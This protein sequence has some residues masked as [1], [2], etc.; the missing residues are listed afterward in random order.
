ML[1]GRALP[2]GGPKPGRAL[3]RVALCTAGMLAVLMPV[4]PSG[5]T[6]RSGR[7]GAAVSDTSPVDLAANVKLSAGKAAAAA[8]VVEGDARFEVLSPELIRLEYSPNAHFLDLPTFDVLDRQFGHPAFTRSVSK[9]WLVLRTSAVELRYRL[10]S[11]PFDPANTKLQ[12]LDAGSGQGTAVSPSWEWECTFGQACQAGAATLSGGAQLAQNHQ[13]YGSPAGFVAGLT[14]TGAAASWE[15]LG[16]PAGTATLT[17][18]YSNSVGLLGG[19][20]PRTMS[21]V[22]DGT[23]TTQVTMQPTASWDDW[24]TVTEPV[25]LTA[26]THTVELGCAATDDCNVNIDSVSLAATGATAVPFLPAGQ[27]GGYIR[28]FDS[29]TYG[30]SPSCGTGQSGDTCAAALPAEAPGLLD[31]S[32]W[33]LLDDT[34]SAVWTSDGWIAARP[35]GDLEDGYLFGYGEH[36]TTA[37]GDFAKL[38]GPAPLPPEYLFG[39]WFSNYYPYAASDYE[40][41]VL[42]AFAANG[43][44]LDTLS[45]DTDWKSPNTWDGW[46]WN[47]SLFPDPAA[48]LSW[49][50]SAGIRVTLNVHSSIATDDPQYAATQ[51]LAGGTLPTTSCDDG[52]C[53]VWDWSQVSQA[54][55]NF[56]L[57][58]P[59]EAQGVSFWWLDWCC[60]ESQASLPGVTPDS[61]IDHLYAQQLT[62]EGARGFV[63]ARIG[64][65]LQEQVPGASPTGAYA[66]H[67]S[68]VHFTGDT[69]STWNTL[70]FEAHLTGDE[71]AIGVPYVSDDIGGFLGPPPGGTTDPADLYLRWLQLGTFQPIMRLHSNGGLRLPWDYGGTTQTIGDQFMQLRESLVPYLYT[72]AAQAASTGIPM[73]QALWL[74]YPSQS[75]A[76]SNPGEYLLG[77]NVLVAPVTSPG[78]VATAKVWLPPGTWVDWFTGATFSG[79]RTVSLSVPLDQMPVFVRAGGIVPLQPPGGRAGTAGSAPITLRV[80]AG[81]AGT[82]TLYDD[83]G[84]GLGYLQGQHSSTPV[85]YT[86]GSAGNSSTVTIGPAAGSYPGAPASRSFTVDLVGVADPSSVSV[87]GRPLPPSGWSYDAATRTLQVA[88]G[89]V[90][91]GESVSLSETG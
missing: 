29:S 74:D 76:Y 28:S 20:A 47:P 55:S 26:G 31:R 69:W 32:G 63:L 83:A 88:L 52:P 30:S 39:N 44:S 62:D 91:V 17:I 4:V 42:P 18:R 27:L 33:S 79:S 50:A 45:V 64:A 7:G 72:L 12:L 56:A 53:A 25:S 60:D 89:A 46:E 37:L 16:A 54:E 40:N 22:L 19:P 21:L 85:G 65:S 6:A 90:A 23:T 77:P 82:F 36:Y 48:F 1:G 5:A 34:A 24:A 49:A 15:V 66:D 87:D 73:T 14:A 58:Q 78:D 80:Y 2:R 11:G 75:A 8:T 38:T 10:G 35:A 57:Q 61:W 3:R 41:T 86:I 84:E 13:N 70:A 59:I 9:G 68:V 67:R 71:A 81:A 43:V 51:A